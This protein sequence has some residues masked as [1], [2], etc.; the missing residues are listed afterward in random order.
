MP[1][2]SKCVR[3]TIKPRVLTKPKSLDRW[4][5]RIRSPREKRMVWWLWPSP[6]REHSALIERPKSR[7][8]LLVEAIRILLMLVHLSILECSQIRW[9]ITIRILRVPNFLKIRR[10]QPLFRWA[11]DLL[12]IWVPSLLNLLVSKLPLLESERLWLLDTSKEVA[13]AVPIVIWWE[14]RWVNTWL[15]RLRAT[16]WTWVAR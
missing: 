4:R 11:R 14:I 15:I 10:L 6:G 13:S 7:L 1:F 9:R 16:S 3:S 5:K 2:T 12:R 8:I